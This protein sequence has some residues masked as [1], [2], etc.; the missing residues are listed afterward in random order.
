[1]ADYRLRKC[2]RLCSRT[3]MDNLF[4]QGQSTIAYPLR[5]VYRYRESGDHFAQ[6]MVTIPKKKI[7]KAVQRVLLRRR[8][9]ESYR[10]HRHELLS[11]TLLA[12]Q[13][14]V[15]VAFIYL[16][17]DVH[18]YALIEAKMRELLTRIARQ[19]HTTPS[20]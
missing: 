6:I 9:R 3:A 7:R 10:L 19:C 11:P 2:E 13:Q 18:P 4:A 1:M 5:A 20:P 17:E 8:I 15:D 14:G 16:S 12:R